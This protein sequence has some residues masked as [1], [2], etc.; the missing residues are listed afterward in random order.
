MRRPSHPILRGKN[1]ILTDENG[2]T[3][4]VTTSNVFQSNGVI[5]VIKTG[6]FQ[7]G[8]AKI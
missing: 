3:A 8:P 6:F 7:I 4:N 2:D 5:H 1:I